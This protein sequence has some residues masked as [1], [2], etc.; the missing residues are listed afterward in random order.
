[1][2]VIAMLSYNSF[3]YIELQVMPDIVRFA[4]TIRV[5]IN[6]LA[7]VLAIV[8][9]NNPPALQ[10]EAAIAASGFCSGCTVV[11]FM[12]KSN[13]P[14]TSL[15]YILVPNFIIYANTMQRNRFWF[16]V[17]ATLSLS[18]LSI[19]GISQVPTVSSLGFQLFLGTMV[20]T[21]AFTLAS[22]YRLEHDE[23]SQYLM[24]RREG[25]LLKA[26]GSA[27]ERLDRLSRTDALTSLFNRRGFEEQLAA[28]WS[29]ARGEHLSLSLL[30]L[31]ID[32]FK[33]YNDHYGHPGGDQCLR[34]VAGAVRSA[35]RFPDDIAARYGGEEFA[36]ILPKTDEAMALGIAERVRQSVLSID[37]LHERSEVAKI[38]TVSIGAATVRPDNTRMT[39]E[40]LIGA[41]DQALY[42]AK[43]KGRNRVA[44]WHETAGG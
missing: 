19:I 10:R 44:Q 42:E 15:Y 33:R 26:L 12:L 41:A 11:L 21:C 14:N 29:Q 24:R 9:V 3:A 4:L 20:T 1:M 6:L 30:L 32:Y 17:T 5:I 13:S 23:R 34:R 35:L 25:H 43:Q 39:A 38:V 36:V 31:D 22:L 7:I 2:L 37:V 27:N 40:Q 18:I 28:C 16:A 8:I